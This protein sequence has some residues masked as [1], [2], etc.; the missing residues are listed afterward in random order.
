M[1]WMNQDME[2]FQYIPFN[3]TQMCKRVLTKIKHYLKRKHEANENWVIDIS[4]Y[5]KLYV[6][7]YVHTGATV[8]CLLMSCN[9]GS[10][11]QQQVWRNNKRPVQYGLWV[12]D[13]D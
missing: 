4:W 5:I 7:M 2:L 8:S 13:C 11:D 1:S 9:L 3:C 10:P 6:N 12:G